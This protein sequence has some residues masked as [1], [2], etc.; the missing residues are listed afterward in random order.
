M[1]PYEPPRAESSDVASS[2]VRKRRNLKRFGVILVL[3]GVLLMI[4]GF[5]VLS[6]TYHLNDPKEDQI[7]HQRAAN[8]GSAI[9]AFGAS[10]TAAGTVCFAAAS[11]SSSAI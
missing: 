4:N 5:G 1:N 10:L 2:R 7:L 6:A 11:K 8:L 9:L 3:C